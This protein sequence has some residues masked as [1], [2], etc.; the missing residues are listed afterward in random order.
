MRALEKAILG[1]LLS[2]LLSNACR[3]TIPRSGTAGVQVNCFVTSFRKNDEP[4]VVLLAKQGRQVSGLKF[5]GKKYSIEVL[6]DI[7]ELEPQ[8][9]HVTHYYGL[10]EVRYQG[11]WSAVCGLWLRWPYPIVFVKRTKNRISQH[12][13]NTRT[14]NSS[15]RL[16]VLREIIDAR[17]NGTEGV[18]SLDLMSLRYGHRWVG[19]P[20]WE[21]HH[22]RLDRLLDLLVEAGDLA[23]A[24]GR[25]RAT[26]QTLL[27]LE[28]AEEADRKHVANYRVQA[29]LAALTLVSS[30]MAAAQA[31]LI[32]LPTLI[33]FSSQPVGQQSSATNPSTCG[34]SAKPPEKK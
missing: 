17:L 30:A 1:I 8:K 25:Y 7:D 29:L 19:H 2:K 34:S 32:K 28:E 24:N 13:F 12:I 18:D 33:D 3:A 31:G 22:E 20:E 14:L 26:G 15:R 21:E 11:L 16:D 4:D 9:M 6:L 27:T 10:D 23:T 5:D